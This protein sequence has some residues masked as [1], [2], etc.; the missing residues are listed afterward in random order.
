LSNL[1]I[2]FE[3]APETNAF[4][5][6]LYAKVVDARENKDDTVYVVRFTSVPYDVE[7]W[8]KGLLGVGSGK[9]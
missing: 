9:V 1:K 3:A 2:E 4:L 8:I 6:E 5:P 7:N